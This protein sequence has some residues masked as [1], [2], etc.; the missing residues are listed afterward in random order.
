MKARKGWDIKPKGWVRE[1]ARHSLARKGIKTAQKTLL[2]ATLKE[3]KTPETKENSIFKELREGYY[4]ITKNKKE[5]WE[6]YGDDFKGDIKKSLEAGKSKEDALEHA[7]E[8]IY[9]YVDET[10]PIGTITIF[11]PDGEK[12]KFQ[13]GEYQDTNLETGEEEENFDFEAKYHKTDAWRGYYEIESKK[14]KLFHGDTA[15]A[16]SEDEAELK[17]FNDTLIE[18][19]RAKG[20]PVAQAVSRTSNVFSASVD[21]FVPKEHAAEADRIAKILA[22]QYRD[23]EKFT[24]TAL[25]GANPSEQTKQDKMFVQGAKHILATGEGAEETIKKIKKGLV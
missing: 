11:Q 16:Y 2:G 15:L 12:L 7:R 18:E 9:Q 4:G 8:L 17:K 24:S 23:E 20:I 1:S 19:L 10:D 25:T 6:N 22:K 14:W 3:T 13:I 21:Y 5:F